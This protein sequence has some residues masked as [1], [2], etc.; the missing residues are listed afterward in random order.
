MYSAK[1]DS[2]ALGII[3][4]F[5]LFKEFPWHGSNTAELIKNY[6]DKD[7]D[8]TSF[9]FLPLEIAAI[10]KGLCNKNIKDRLQLLNC[11]FKIFLTQKCIKEIN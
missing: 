9:Q 1:S 3:I 6:K 5:L 10:V 4:Y 11:D 8:W 7:I 2:F